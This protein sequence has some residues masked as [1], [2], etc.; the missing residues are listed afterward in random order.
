LKQGG[1]FVDAKGLLQFQVNGSFKMLTEI[2]QGASDA[3]W[4]ARSF[5][6]A[7]MIGFTIWHCARTIDWAVNCVMRGAS[8]LADQSE[9][10]D[11]KMAD[12]VFGAGASR[13]A[14]DN[15][16]RDVSRTRVAAYIEALR[17]D[18]V[19]WLADVSNEDLSATVDLKARHAAKPQYMT[20]HVWEEIEDLNGIP[21]WQFL[22]R[23]SVSH[24]RVH[25]GEVTSQLGALRTATAAS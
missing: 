16:A 6:T 5:P 23:P 4:K 1:V 12:A 24:I 10:H 20:P 9:W 2:A 3:E 13:E 14:A 18:T 19:A 17:Q 11:L 25:Y 22:A 15:V 8:E 7:N 21:G